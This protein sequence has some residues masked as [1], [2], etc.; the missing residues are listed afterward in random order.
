V[1]RSK[2]DASKRNR[3]L[4]RLTRRRLRYKASP[5]PGLSATYHGEADPGFDVIQHPIDVEKQKSSGGVSL[6]HDVVAGVWQPPSPV[7]PKPRAFV[8]QFVDWEIL[9]QS[10]AMLVAGD[11]PALA[12]G[13]GGMRG[14][15]YDWALHIG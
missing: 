3:H 6:A 2:A 9:R 11:L 12:Y 14:L 10:S 8:P 7:W 13:S 4:L 1:P 15:A 5:A